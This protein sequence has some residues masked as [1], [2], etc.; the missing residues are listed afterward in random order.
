MNAI[1]PTTSAEPTAMPPAPRGLTLGRRL[2]LA[3]G[4][5]ALGVALLG[6]VTW[7][8]GSRTTAVAS[9]LS[10]TQLPLERLVHGWKADAIKLG[11]LALRSTQSN[12]VFPVVHELRAVARAED[13]RVQAIS[14][15]LPPGDAAAAEAMAAALVQRAVYQKLR[16]A[17]AEQALTAQ[18]ISQKA[19]AE[20]AAAL[21]A[22]QGAL[23]RMLAL[24]EAG[25]RE[26][27]G[28]LIASARR[29][30]AVSAAAVLA[31]LALAGLSGWLLHRG[32]V[33]P[34][35]QASAVAHDVA[36]GRLQVALHAP[37]HDEIGAL[38]RALSTMGASLNRVVREVRDAGDAISTASSEVAS[39][40]DDLS[41]RTEESAAGLQRAAASMGQLTSAVQANAASTREAARMAESASERAARSGQLVA[42]VVQTMAAI[43]ASSRK[44][45]DII[46]TID[47]IAFQTNILALN[48]AVEAARAGEQGRGFAVVASEVR[49]LA[50][51]SASAAKEIKGLIA[52]SVATVSGGS[53]LV[54][55]AGQGMAELVASVGE[56]TRLVAAISTANEAQSQ[57]IGGVGQAIAEL[58]RITQQNAALVEEGA[59]AA[60]SLKD[61]ARRLTQAVGVFRL[62]PGAGVR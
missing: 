41:R 16:D 48:A 1:A 54:R 5:V 20:H 17:V 43:D 33:G 6:A 44:I 11:E 23:D 27:A 7:H 34:L 36:A 32:I 37:R 42:D 3:F 47:G 19:L 26:A 62:Q 35:A 2:G 25:S 30:Q 53:G 46:G 10:A 60:G 50:Q 59:A 24:S 29:A 22:Y 55:A 12:D 45:A 39:A 38:L 52:D 18:V 13:Q 40:N 4:L 58:D 28:T 9:R 8:T 56:V 14:G 31:V 49:S 21:Q 57:E 61:L 51:R 15:Q